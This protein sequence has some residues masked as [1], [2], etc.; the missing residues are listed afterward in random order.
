[1][2]SSNYIVLVYADA[3]DGSR[4]RPRFSNHYDKFRHQSGRVEIRLL[5]AT[6]GFDSRDGTVR[7]NL[8][9]KA[10]AKTSSMALPLN[11]AE[12]PEA[13]DAS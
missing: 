13:F 5:E 2:R 12:V 10:A 7:A 11:D 6:Y 3:N 4:A 1:V 8:H 9:E